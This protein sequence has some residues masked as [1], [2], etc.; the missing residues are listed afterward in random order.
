MASPSPLQLTPKVGPSSTLA[1]DASAQRLCEADIQLRLAHLPAWTVDQQVLRRSFCFASFAEAIAFMSAV[2]QV[3]EA[4]NHHPDWCNRYR[5][6]DV[7]L[8]THD[9]GGLTA[10]DFQLAAD[11]ERLAE[12]RA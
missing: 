1:A 11:M 10:L 9:A 2:A 7:R 8:T 5:Q 4:L 6:V 12:G 3:A